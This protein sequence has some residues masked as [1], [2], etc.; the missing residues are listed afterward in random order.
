MIRSLP[1]P[2][3]S[4]RWAGS[5]RWWR[6]FML[7]TVVVAGGSPRIA[8]GQSWS[9]M[10]KVVE[11]EQIDAVRG[12]QNVIHLVSSR[13]YQLD[14]KGKVMVNE[15]VGDGQQS[16]MLF[17]PAIAA[18]DDGTV[19]LITRHGGSMD[20]GFD[21]RYRR[22]NG[23][24]KWDRDYLVGSRVKRNY[25][26]GATWAGASSVYLGTS[27][28]GSNVWGDLHLW[29]AGASSATKLGS[30]GGIWRADCDARLRAVG[31]RVFWASGKTDGGGTG[32]YVL[33]GLAGSQLVSQL[34]KN[35]VMHKGT[36]RTGFPDLYVDAS[37]TVHLTHG[38]EKAV[39]YNKYS[40]T[41][42][43]LLASDKQIFSGLGS[44]HLSTGLSAVAASDDG[45]TILAV[46][47][48]SDGSQQASNSDL[49]WT[50]SKNGGASFSAAQDLKKNTD[51]GEGRR[52][53]RLVAI[54]NT[55]YLFYRDKAFKGISLAM[56]KVVVGVDGGVVDGPTA[57]SDGPAIGSDGPANDVRIDGVVVSSDGSEGDGPSATAVQG[58][59][60]C[61]GGGSGEPGGLLGL[62]L[63]GLAFRKRR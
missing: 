48:R 43:K 45:Q 44:W 11:G 28:A 17:P 39:L 63:C 38:A 52:R 5:A 61:Q 47:L 15:A 16:S 2:A 36:G 24:G 57:G 34:G 31:G 46:A 1:T 20:G 26:V 51:G 19:H 42:K 14:A 55:F 32:T 37:K 35:K 10:G 53:P 27:Q 13:Y 33:H 25:V 12:P 6:A 21:L 62:L 7:A 59:C 23:A 41:G 40:A 50:L 56:L 22:R 49:L 60:A 54:G 18:G 4:P 3:G 30:I 29:Q 8:L 58:G 9:F